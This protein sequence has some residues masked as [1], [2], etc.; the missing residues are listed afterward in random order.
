MRLILVHRVYF[1]ST[2]FQIK[3]ST[4]QIGKECLFFAN[5]RSVIFHLTLWQQRFT[6]YPATKNICPSSR[7]S[8]V[9]FRQSRVLLLAMAFY[10]VR[11]W[12]SGRWLWENVYWVTNSNWPNITTTSL[13]WIS[14]T[15]L[16]T[17]VKVRFAL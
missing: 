15:F 10:H 5:V 14:T 13:P 4:L 9:A 2:R 16:R 12:E 3:N 6:S 7:M 8:T 11:W 17:R 1:G